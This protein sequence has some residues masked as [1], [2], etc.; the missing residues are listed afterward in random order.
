MENFMEMLS[1]SLNFRD[2]IP[3]SYRQHVTLQAVLAPFYVLHV[4]HRLAKNITK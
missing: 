2:L 1:I 4:F 3:L